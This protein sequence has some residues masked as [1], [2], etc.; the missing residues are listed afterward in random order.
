LCIEDEK[1]KAEFQS[2]V[3]TDDL[4]DPLKLEVCCLTPRTLH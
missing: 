1:L 3:S 4:P 2:L